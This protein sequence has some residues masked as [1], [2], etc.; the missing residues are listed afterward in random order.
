MAHQPDDT[1]VEVGRFDWERRLRAATLTAQAKLF[2]VWLATYG[3]ADGT[4]IH[5]GEERLSAD[6]GLTV[7]TVRKHMRTLRET[8]W[9]RRVERSGRRT[10]H[11]DSYRL[12]SP[13]TSSPV[14][15]SPV[16]TSPVKNSGITGDKVA[17]SPVRNPTP[18]RTG[19]DHHQTTTR[20]ARGGE[21]W[22]S[23]IDL[24]ARAAALVGDRMTQSE[25]ESGFNRLDHD[26][27]VKTAYGLI[28]SLVQ[29]GDPDALSAKLRGE[30]W[31]PRATSP[32]RPTP[33]PLPELCG[34]CDARPGDPPT[35]RIVWLDED[36]RES[37]PCPRCNPKAVGVTRVPA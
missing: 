18:T 16:T 2:G 24:L 11:A 21:R 28:D 6:T 15:K 25:I 34:L 23:T 22:R 14:N 37:E 12:T 5:P 20:E 29:G 30:R 33:T 27:S 19:P 9:L 13:V 32:Y 36:H 8:G 4:S 26:P 17:R 7:Q 35:A 10:G 1:S 3:D 31:P